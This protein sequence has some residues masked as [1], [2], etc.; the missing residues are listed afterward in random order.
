M[1]NT[2]TADAHTPC[3]EQQSSLNCS[4]TGSFFFVKLN[5]FFTHF[6]F[7]LL[8]FSPLLLLHLLWGYNDFFIKFEASHTQDILVTSSNRDAR[9]FKL[10]AQ[11]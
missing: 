11:I 6:A 10:K 8:H 3:H 4:A 5:I 1:H 9:P 2:R 7:A